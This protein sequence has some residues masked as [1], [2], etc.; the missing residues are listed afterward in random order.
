MPN[1]I[2]RYQ[3]GVRMAF[4]LGASGRR[5]ANAKNFCLFSENPEP[6]NHSQAAMVVFGRLILAFIHCFN[7]QPETALQNAQAALQESDA[8]G[9]HV[10]DPL[11]LT[12]A[13]YVCLYLEDTKGA[14]A[15]LKRMQR[16]V[17]QSTANINT[18]YF[19]M[20]SAWRAAK[21]GRYAQA[22][23]NAQ[24]ALHIMRAQGAVFPQ[25]LCELV[26]AYVYFEQDQW[27]QAETL[28][29]KVLQSATDSGFRWLSVMGHL[30]SAALAQRQKR[31]PVMLASLREGLS[32]ARQCLYGQPL[33]MQKSL[34]A[35]LYNAALANDIEAEYVVGVI[36]QSALLPADGTAP[37]EYWP[38]PIQ[39]STF[40]HF[41]VLIGGEPINMSGKAQLKPMGLLK[42]LIAFGA[43]EVGQTKLTDQLWPDAEGDAARR[44]FNTTLHRLRKAL[45]HDQ[46]LLLK[47]GKLS[48]NSKY[49]WVDVWAFDYLHHA[50]MAALDDYGQDSDDAQVIE[51]SRDL[52]RIY[53][54]D[55]LQNDGDETWVLAQ[56]EKCHG[57]MVKCL[58]QLIAYYDR[59]GQWDDVLNV[60]EYGLEVDPVLEEFYQTAMNVHINAGRYAEVIAIYNRCKLNLRSRLGIM[61]SP[62]TEKFR[63]Q[64]LGKNSIHVAEHGRRLA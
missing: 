54:G 44:A 12:V 6:G 23:Q 35:Q 5:L 21:A 30:F 61:P 50:C 36:R 1:C 18:G 55:F 51:T 7:G 9:L 40:G 52:F 38:W 63:Q 33:L 10:L 41:H 26:L 27:P 17:S 64:V 4:Y 29:G 34:V 13:I 32:L 62:V 39:V 60:C 2:A 37:L 56:R 31:H 58:R 53:Q 25:A 46:A 16:L 14:D 19:Y 57:R 28:I 47:D 24:A 15:L 59:R 48:L 49:C 43:N 45:G 3:L 11:L 8:K 20:L 22:D 42:A